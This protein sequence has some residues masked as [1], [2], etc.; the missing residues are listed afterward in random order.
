MKMDL[1]LD[2]RKVEAML[3]AKGSNLKSALKTAA[4]STAEKGIDIIE[5]RTARGMGIYSPFVGYSPKYKEWKLS[6]NPTGTVNLELSGDMLGAMNA[7][8]LGFKVGAEIGFNRLNEAR[9]AVRNNQIR[10]FF[11]FNNREQNKLKRWFMSKI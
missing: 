1:E 7:T 3:K 6:K 11:G 9:K 10:P 5:S 4:L 8:K 2:S